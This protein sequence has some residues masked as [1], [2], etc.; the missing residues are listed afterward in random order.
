VTL[1]A[2]GIRALLTDM[3]WEA[4]GMAVA[5]IKLQ[6]A[7]ED[8]D[9]AAE[10]LSQHGHTITSAEP[11]DEAAPDKITC[12]ECGTEIPEGQSKC[13]ACGWTYVA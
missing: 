9:Q 4:L 12:L 11:D 1:E 3:D 7:P 8:A 13:P 6:V 2:E 5:N 10:L